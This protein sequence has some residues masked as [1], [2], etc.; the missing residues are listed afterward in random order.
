MSLFE[1][2]SSI[3]VGDKIEKKS[4]LSYLSWSW[5]WS[6]FKRHCPDANYEIMMF[7]GRPYLYDENLGYLCM[8]TVTANGESHT[9]WLPVM[10]SGNNSMKGFPYTIPT[11]YGEM[12]VQAATMFDINKA[13]MC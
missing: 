12:A 10:D 6:E 4:N 1:E 13:L 9:M 5:A 11:K 7:D 3:D 2:L 8:V